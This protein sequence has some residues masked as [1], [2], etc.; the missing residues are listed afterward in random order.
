MAV[1]I[2]KP[3]GT[4]DIFPSEARLWQKIEKTARDV[5]SRY[6]FGEIRTP[7]FEELSLFKRG[8]GEVTDVVQRKCT[9]LL[10]GRIGFLP[11]ALRVL[12]PVCVL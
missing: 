6:G 9:P 12:L 1:K 2:Q 11:F 4:M 10:I 8:V 5:A 3:R 7:T